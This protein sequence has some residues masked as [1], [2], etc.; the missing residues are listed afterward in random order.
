MIAD[1]LGRQIRPRVNVAPRTYFSK[2][3]LDL[4]CELRLCERPLTTDNE[5]GETYASGER[6]FR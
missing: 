5:D 4:R 2:N 1:D 6:L 3:I